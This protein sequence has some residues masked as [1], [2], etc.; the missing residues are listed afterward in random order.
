MLTGEQEFALLAC[1]AGPAEEARH[2]IR[3]WRDRL[4]VDDL[5][6]AFVAMLNARTLMDRVDGILRATMALLEPPRYHSPHNVYPALRTIVGEL[7]EAAWFLEKET[8]NQLSRLI[9]E[10]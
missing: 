1:A 10:E 5:G 2:T 8:S 4:E 3:K 6:G 9:T 7:G